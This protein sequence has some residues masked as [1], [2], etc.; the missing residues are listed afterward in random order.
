MKKKVDEQEE[1]EYYFTADVEGEEGQSGPLVITRELKSCQMLEVEDVHF[2]HNSAVVLPE[3]LGELACCYLYAM[4]NSSKLM[5]IAGH[6][7]KSGE[8]SYNQWL[9]KKRAENVLNILLGRRTAWV[10]SVTS[11]TGPTQKP[12]KGKSKVED[13]Q[14][15][16]K[17]VATK[18]G[19]AC[20]PGEVEDGWPCDT[21]DTKK[22]T[23]VFQKNYNSELRAR[24]GGK[25]I[26]EDGLI[27]PETWGAFFDIYMLE[28]AELLG[29]DS[30]TSRLENYRN[31]LKFIDDRRIVGGGESHAR[32]RLERSLEDRRVHIL[33]FDPDEK[34]KLDYHPD[35]HKVPPYNQEQA[36]K[37]ELYGKPGIYGKTPMTCDL[38]HILFIEVI[39]REGKHMAGVK[40]VVEREGEGLFKTG[41][42]NTNGVFLVRD[43][44]KGT[45]IVTVDT[46]NLPSLARFKEVEER[47]E[48]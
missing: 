34:P 38:D 23:E 8:A 1:L 16:L 36:K 20:D 39:D 14:M 41:N 32:D 12:P 25:S 2:N 45:Y 10:D 4:E 40:V 19:W 31:A 33:F 24:V 30:D 47:V 37:C 43:V 21:S 29:L 13:Y 18:Y 6:T 44:P 15:I 35:C 48:I 5:L 9:S 27:G 11:K 17:W 22:A 26:K 46:Q 42:T 28:L 3:A 7:D